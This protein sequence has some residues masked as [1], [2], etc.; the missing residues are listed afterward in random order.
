MN[1]LDNFRQLD[2]VRKAAG[3]RRGG[4][5]APPMHISKAQ[6]NAIKTEEEARTYVEHLFEKNNVE[7]MVGSGEAIQNVSLD[8]IRQAREN[9]RA[10]LA[11]RDAIQKAW[12][13]TPSP[14]AGL[15]M[16][17]LEKPAKLLYPVM[18]PVRNLL[19]RAK[20]AGTATN[21]RGVIGIDPNNIGIGVTTGSRAGVMS[22]ID[23]AFTL[24]FR[25]IGMENFVTFEAQASA[26]G[27]ED[28]LALA[29]LQTLQDLMIGEE[30]NILGGI[31][32]P[33]EIVGSNFQLATPTGMGSVVN[34]TGGSGFAAT[35]HL[36]LGGVP[37]QPGWVQPNHIYGRFTQH[38]ANDSV[39]EHYYPDQRGRFHHGVQCRVWTGLRRPDLYFNCRDNQLDHA[40]L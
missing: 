31:G 5:T 16:Y 3:G 19:P 1:I 13:V 26:A 35:Y 39:S 30:F 15:Q 9:A 24:P 10:Y 14:I 7:K 38:Y 22:Q 4:F 6:V 23:F 28:L 29:V 18:C 33:N 25:T 36:S 17:D 12:D 11:C 21:W 37:D 20:G 40:I 34:A 8:M 27:F 2:R 32:N